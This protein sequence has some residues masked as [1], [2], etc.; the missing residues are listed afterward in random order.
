MRKLIALT[1]ALM[2]AVALMLP[3]PVSAEEGYTEDMT[4]AVAT[5]AMA[6]DAETAEAVTE[7]I[8]EVAADLTADTKSAETVPEP[9]GSETSVPFDEWLY[10]AIKQATPEQ[11]DMVEKIVMGG[12]NALDKLGI[13][14]FDRVRI[15]VEYNTATVMVA[16]LA[17]GLVLFFVGM[18]L[19]KKGFAKGTAMLHSDAKDFYAAGQANVD[20]AVKTCKEYADLTDRVCRECADAAKEAAESAKAAQGQVTEERALLISELDRSNKVNAAMCETVNFLLQCSDLSQAKRDEAEAIFKRGM[21]A[22]NGY[23][24]P[25]TE[26]VKLDEEHDQA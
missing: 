9:A 7:E 18:V 22:L 8:S 15:W 12:V 10:D 25:P 16:A 24:E 14:G 6:T 26:E 2:L 17:I 20:K 19:Q 23:A 21:E 5:V 4:V 13:K 3:L 1:M 11:M